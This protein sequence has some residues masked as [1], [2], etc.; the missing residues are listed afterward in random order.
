M[1]SPTKR[2]ERMDSNILN[3][4]EVI[5]EQKSEIKELKRSNKG[6]QQMARRATKAGKEANALLR[7]VM[8]KLEKPT[9]H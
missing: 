4:R 5:K 7:K 3:L 2:I 6:F 1:H 9:L 8:E